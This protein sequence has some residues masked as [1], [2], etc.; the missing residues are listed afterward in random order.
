MA[1]IYSIRKGGR[2]YIGLASGAAGHVDYQKSLG[3]REP[4]DRMLQHIDNA[5]GLQ[6]SYALVRGTLDTETSKQLE[7]ALRSGG[8]CKCYFS[9]NDD[10]D[11]CFGIG[12]DLFQQFSKI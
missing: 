10:E 1:Y 6:S 4:L 3:A 9:Y 11:S 12:D 8:A 2:G 7:Q 5:Y